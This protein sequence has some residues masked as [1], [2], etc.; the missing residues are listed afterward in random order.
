MLTIRHQSMNK[1]QSP[2]HT[3]LLVILLLTTLMKKAP[4]GHTTELI[5]LD[6]ESDQAMFSAEFRPRSNALT[7]QT[8]KSF[9]FAS[10]A[11]VS[12]FVLNALSMVLQKIFS[13]K[14][15][16][17]DVKTIKKSYPIIKS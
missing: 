10:I 8:S 14:H 17:H 12:A 2:N 15:K 9:I 16:E 7:I 6:L 1:S 13:G 4:I 11:N 5:G 3:L